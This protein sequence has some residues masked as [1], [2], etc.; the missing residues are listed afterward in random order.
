MIL[1]DLFRTVLC[2]LNEWHRLF[3]PRS[4]HHT[5]LTVLKRA[6]CLGNY[7]SDTVYHL[8]SHRNS[9]LDTNIDCLVGHELRLCGHNRL[10]CGRL[11]HFVTR[12]FL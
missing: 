6:E 8:D 12:T 7:V 5:L 2:R 4:V 3:L 10:A 9:V 11:R 1:D